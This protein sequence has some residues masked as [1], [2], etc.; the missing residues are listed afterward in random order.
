MKRPPTSLTP[1]VIRDLGSNRITLM[2][3]LTRLVKMKQKI[4]CRKYWKTKIS[5]QN[6]RARIRKLRNLDRKSSQK[7]RG[8]R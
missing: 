3:S 4:S 7:G 2:R 6:K 1:L 5:P 8:I